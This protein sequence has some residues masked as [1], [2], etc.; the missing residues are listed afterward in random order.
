M[1]RTRAEFD[2]EDADRVKM[3]AA[4][5]RRAQVQEMADLYQIP[6]Y[7]RPDGSIHQRPPGEC[8]RPADCDSG[9]DSVIRISPEEQK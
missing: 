4:G 7:L 8:F 5:R 1:P 2:Q 3:R 9:F 6:F